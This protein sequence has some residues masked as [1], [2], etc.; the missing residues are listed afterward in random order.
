MN[1]PADKGVCEHCG[2]LDVGG[3][4]GCQLL[5]DEVVAK[6]FGQLGYFSV[7]RAALDCYCM[8]HPEIY[9][10][11]A[12]SYAA[13]LAG[14]CT[15]MEFEGR[16]ETHAAI[17]RWL[18]GTVALQK[19][20]LLTFRGELTILHLQETGDLADY[21]RR[22]REWAGSVWKAYSEQQDVGR[23]YVRAALASSR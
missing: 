17:Q 2:A 6:S 20:E 22:V 21:R 15:E 11:S 12:K 5:M 9:G 3:Y 18:S 8:Q 7:Y 19:P 14:L 13:H 23:G 16:R 10:I 4:A 1:Q